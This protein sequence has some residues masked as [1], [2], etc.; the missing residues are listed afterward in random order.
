MV[1]ASS[2]LTTVAVVGA[3]A[4]K[5]GDASLDSFYPI[6]RHHPQMQQVETY[7]QARQ[8]PS[9]PPLTPLRWLLLVQAAVSSGR[10]SIVSSLAA[11]FCYVC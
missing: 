11:T 3:C 8:P 5:K 2:L 7:A 1:V 4:G 9:L 6:L 10:L